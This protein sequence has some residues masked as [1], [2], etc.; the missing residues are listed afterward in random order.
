MNGKKRYLV[1]ALLLLLGFGAMTFAGGNDELEP[2]DGN[3]SG[4]VDG[5]GDST[6]QRVDD[7]FNSDIVEDQNIVDDNNNVVAN[8]NAGNQNGNPGNGNN[9][10]VIPTVNPETLIAEVEKMLGEATKK[11]DVDGAHKYFTD[12]E[13]KDLTEALENGENKDNLLERVEKLEKVFG[14]N[15]S[16]L[17]N[18]I[19]PNEVTNKPVTITIEDATE[20][21]KTVMLNGEEIEFVEPFTEDGVYTIT[22]T[23]EAHNENS[24][25][26]TIDTVLPKVN[27]ESGK[28]YNEF[29][30]NVEEDNNFTINVTKNHNET[31]EVENGTQFTEDATYKFVI[32]DEA[33]NTITIWSAIDNENP[34]I[35]VTDTE[36]EGV[37]CKRLTVTDRYLMNLFVN[38]TKY[39]RNNFTSGANNEYFKY[40]ETI[41]DEGE[42]V[43][44]AEDKIGN[45]YSETFTIDRSA[46][47]VSYSTIRIDNKKGYNTQTYNKYTTTYYVTD[48]DVFTYAIAFEEKLA[49]AP[50]L[51][52]GGKEVTLEFVDKETIVNDKRVYLYEGKM[53]VLETDNFAQGELRVEL[54]NIVDEFGNEVTD[55]A[56]LKPNETTNHRVISYDS[57]APKLNYVAILSKKDNYDKAI[58]GDTIRFLVRFNEEMNTDNFKLKFDGKVIKFVKSQDVGY[59]YIVDYKIP[60]DTKMETGYLTF[61]VFGYTDKAGNGGDAITVANH[62]KYNKVY[63]D[64]IAPTIKMVGTM[65][66]NNNE[67]RVPVGSFLDLETIEATV[68]DNSLENPIKVRPV[69]IMKYY[70]ASFNKA[71]HVYEIDEN[72]LFDTDTVG[73][74]Y[75]VTYS[76]TD[77]SGY[78]TTR[79]ML[80]IIDDYKNPVAVDM[81]THREINV[82]KNVNSGY[83]PFYNEVNND[84]DLVINGNGH[85]VTQ[86]VQDFTFYWNDIYNDYNAVRPVIANLF[87]TQDNKN[88]TINDLTFKGTTQFISL[89]HW[90]STNGAASGNYSFNLNNVNVVG[91]EY[92][93]RLTVGVAPAV[94]VYGN[95]VFDDVNIY[96]NHLSEKFM[97]YG[98]TEWDVV[99]ND[100]SNGIIKNSKI[101]TLRTWTR[102]SLVIENTDIKLLQVGAR[103]AHN[104]VVTIKA[105]TVIDKLV[106]GM[107]DAV[108][109][110]EEGAIVKELDYNNKVASKLTL[111]IAEGTVLSE[112]NKK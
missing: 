6:P 44:L 64:A 73:V 39:N 100:Y 78:T 79:T 33:G 82:T 35:V 43:V 103:K 60:Q 28:H 89:G 93:S 24:V 18:G 102:T 62:G 69:S 21:T 20:V 4:Q 94:L 109:N 87:S 12:N 45:A 67:H 101:G 112:V 110:I 32:T 3:N 99:T 50:K 10:P 1:L 81:G 49:Q 95:F 75:N 108:L 77:D 90:N 7:A 80:L 105:G 66:K 34:N 55:E 53:E 65:G 91:L 107:G 22:V 16:P 70:P 15:D 38:E 86:T 96:D 30:L 11:E 29:T 74:R 17:I 57:V 41:C 8:P 37:A 25:T 72:S 47:K 98:D 63:F 13:V 27:I 76:Y 51:T 92:A 31:Y 26:F 106:I 19:N 68:S 85:T 97:P 61:E 36:V 42:Y 56:I 84:K 52:I 54:S 104:G 71:G 83:L 23:D 88:I 5:N 111:N 48:G 59:E 46:A 9:N 58:K 2:A 40:E 14:D